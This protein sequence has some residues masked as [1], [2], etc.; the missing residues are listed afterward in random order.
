MQRVK[1]ALL[2]WGWFYLIISFSNFK[3]YKQKG[4]GTYLVLKWDFTQDEKKDNFKLERKPL[5]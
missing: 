1:V 2:A 3:S 4:E 5:K